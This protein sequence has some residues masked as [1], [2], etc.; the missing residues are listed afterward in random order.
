[1]ESDNPAIQSAQIREAIFRGFDRENDSIFTK[2]GH[3]RLGFILADCL[4][5]SMKKQIWNHHCAREL[6]N[7]YVQDT[8]CKRA[9]LATDANYLD[10]C[11]YIQR[12]LENRNS[13]SDRLNA[14]VE[15]RQAK[16]SGKLELFRASWI[17][18]YPDAENYLGLFYS[19]TFRP[20]DP[21]IPII[22]IHNTINGLRKLFTK[23]PKK[24]QSTT[25]R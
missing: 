25:G 14:H 5:K 7:A 13:N 4:G 22:Q 20:M 17:A 21:I 15:F 2:Y 10:M 3:F 19:K 1:M 12:E 8:V 9:R 16:T 6:V 24:E 11:K 23:D 18:D